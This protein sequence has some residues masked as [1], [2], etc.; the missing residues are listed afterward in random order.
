MSMISL[1]PEQHEL[2]VKG[3]MERFFAPLPTEDMF[4]IIPLHA[5]DGDDDIEEYCY[6]R[7][8]REKCLGIA[9]NIPVK[10]LDELF[11]NAEK[12]RVWLEGDI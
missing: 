8:E 2:L 6:E 4:E 10:S 9:C 7:E 1:T 5:Q 12:V 3:G 11:A